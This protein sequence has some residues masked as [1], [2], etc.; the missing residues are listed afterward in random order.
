MDVADLVL[1]MTP[2]AVIQAMERALG[3]HRAG[4]LA[5]AEAVY[6]Q[7]LAHFPT[8]AP[9]RH[10]LGVIA[11]QRGDFA[12]AIELIG[13]AV[14]AEPGVAEYQSNLGEFYRRAGRFDEAIA[15]FERAVALQPGLA[16]AHGNLGNALRAAGR[17]D[18]AVA[19]Y[20]RA[21]ALEP[22]S[23]EFPGNLGLALQE[24]G[25]LD[26]AI[27]AHERSVALGPNDPVAHR[28]LGIALHA[29]GRS[30]QAVAAY[31]RALALRENDA[32]TYCNLGMTLQETGHSA[33]AIAALQNAVALDPNLA[34]AWTNLGNGLWAAGRF[35]EASVAL[36][37]ALTLNPR[38]ADGHNNLGNVLKDQ[39][40]LD[41]AIEEFRRAMALRPES[42]RA[43]SN[44]LFALWAHPGYDAQAILAEHRAW[45]RRHADPLPLGERG[46]RPGEG[47]RESERLGLGEG[48]RATSS[49]GRPLRIGYVSPDF[50][51]HPVGH[52]LVPL[53]THHDRRQFEIVAYSDV[54]A[55]DA[56]TETL[57]S[58]AD[59]WC[60]TVGLSDAQVAERV[61]ADRI[62][63]LVDLALH[64]AGNR[65]LVFA[66]KPA[67]V[68]VTML[69]LPA[70]TGL[71]TM[72][73]RLTDA[74]L[75]PPGT[76]E[77][78]YTECSIRLPHCFWVFQPPEEAPEPGALPAL[79]NGFVTFGCLNQFA[80]V[81]PTALDLWVRILQA[82]PESRLVI[83]AQP[84]S[85]LESVRDRFLQGGIAATRLEF[86]P[87]VPRADYFRRYLQL[88]L[89][90]DPFPYNG[91]NCT[92]ESL[93]MGVPVVTLAGRTAV[94]RGG[95]SILS[96][97]GLPELIARSTEEYVNIAVGLAR[98]H[99]RLAELRRGLRTRMLAS[100][101]TD[102]KGYTAAVEAAFRVMWERWCGS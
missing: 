38:D 26:E 4:Q 70:T 100:P 92:I 90:L 73:Y 19:A 61:R 49:P 82:I 34:Q 101:L 53:F 33:A 32:R 102:G 1:L 52:L 6:R 46:R 30:D 56:S 63:I 80:K 91:H 93:W 36:R 72:D 88:D 13:Q 83:Q 65:L 97:A 42:P 79:Q 99:E 15:R 69:G 84:G 87:R 59:Q 8:F 76:S 16:V 77:I 39:G 85:H 86:V 31:R 43:G 78:D 22:Q 11:G 74:Y 28:N 24:M 94:A 89:G 17:L 20:G 40:R 35:D 67:P 5:E 81:S 55:P 10:W 68:Q 62:D 25:R 45:A 12:R 41:E 58:L 66:R 75:D 98:D 95:V 9:A 57:K 23:A 3:H 54:R 64:T 37:R 47:Q 7:V 96:N 21:M 2:I 51:G 71:A 60:P 18:E 27:T 48:P 14:A 44:L 29:A 50:R